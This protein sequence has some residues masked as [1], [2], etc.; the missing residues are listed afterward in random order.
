MVQLARVRD[1]MT[2]N[3]LTLRDD[4][5]LRQAVEVVMVRRIRHIPVLDRGGGLVAAPAA[6]A[7]PGK[8]GRR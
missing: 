1:Y 2:K 5:L 8:P 4:D 7:G 6:E 3:P